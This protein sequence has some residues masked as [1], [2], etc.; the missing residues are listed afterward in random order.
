[1][2]A[3]NNAGGG[4]GSSASGGGDLHPVTHIPD[5]SFFVRWEAFPSFPGDAFC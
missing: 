2:M 3:G 5:L 1:M 4:A